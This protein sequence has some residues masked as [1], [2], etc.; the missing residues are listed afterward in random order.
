MA[1]SGRVSVVVPFYNEDVEVL[2]RCVKSIL[3]QSYNYIDITVVNDG[4]DKIDRMA[5]QRML[6]DYDVQMI[7]IEHGGAPKARND[8]AWATN[9]EYLF[10][11]DAD[12]ELASDCFY[13]MMQKLHEN[14]NA[15]WCYC[16]YNLGKRWK[17]FW[18]FDKKIMYRKNCSSTMSLMRR[19]A[20]LWFDESLKRYQDWDL[21]LRMMENGSEGVWC[22]KTLFTALDRKGISNN[23][24]SDSEARAVLHKKNKKI[25]L[26]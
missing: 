26:R 12:V 21:F 8:G 3:L 20:F 4:S 9:G 6:L 24:I 14:K 15:D 10:F 7:D 19:N 23:S 13:F 25:S 11:C 17:H 1:R 5:M 18:E 22:N 2:E 16:N